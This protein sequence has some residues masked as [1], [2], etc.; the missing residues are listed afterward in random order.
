MKSKG[1]IITPDEVVE[2][3]G[4]DALRTYELFL[5]P[6]EQDA[7]W[8]DRG[9]NGVFKFLKRVWRLILKESPLIFKQKPSLLSRTLHTV[10][11]LLHVLLL[12]HINQLA[13][14]TL[15]YPAQKDH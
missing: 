5:G 11:A 2:E 7:I 14:N 3:Y 9:I 8:N 15:F 6:F 10:D 4:A 13:S 12:Q 1:N